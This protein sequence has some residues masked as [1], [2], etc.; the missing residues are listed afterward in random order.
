[1][2]KKHVIG[3][4]LVY[5][6]LALPF[7]LDFPYYW[8]YQLKT[9]N[10]AEKFIDQKQYDIWSL[11]LHLRS[12]A[13]RIDMEEKHPDI[14]KDKWILENI[15]NPRASSSF[16]PTQ[17]H[18]IFVALLIDVSSQNVQ[19]ACHPFWNQTNFVLGVWPPVPGVFHKERRGDPEFWG[20]CRPLG[21]GH[22]Q[23]KFQRRSSEAA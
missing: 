13:H 21:T 20:H 18:Y 9:S 22:L 23:R 11:K 2:K 19:I 14:I 17:S 4:Q 10:N 5:Q 7:F 8:K 16:L 12:K 15:K 1:M 6:R 3:V